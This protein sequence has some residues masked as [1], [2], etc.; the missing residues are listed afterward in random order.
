MCEK[1]VLSSNNKKKIAELETLFR[2]YSSDKTEIFS[3]KDV[4]I[5]DPIEENGSSFEENAI[6]KASVPAKLGY[7]GI[8]DDSGLVVDALNGEPGIY[9]ARYAS[10]NKKC[11]SSDSENNKKLLENLKNVAY[12]QRTARF[13]CAVACVFPDGEKF[14][15]RGECEGVILNFPSGD[16]GFGYDPLFYYPPLDKTFAQL[17]SDEKNKVSHRG[18]AMRE[19]LEIF[20]EKYNQ[21]YKK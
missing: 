12:E 10:D 6:I 1:I 20:K 2:Q 3:L 21:K 16:G 7:I 19:F 13:V 9:S 14:T 18:K 4:G 8:A 15:V 5:I 11:D 17:T